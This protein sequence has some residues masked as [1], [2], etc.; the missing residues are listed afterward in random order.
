MNA[1][2]Y[3]GNYQAG[4]KY[5]ERPGAYALLLNPVGLLGRVELPQGYF[6]PGGGIENG[7]NAESALLREIAEETAFQARL[8]LT[9]GEATEYIYTPGKY[10]TGMA[11]PSTFFVAEITEPTGSPS[12][13]PIDWVTPE[14]LQKSLLHQSQQWAVRQF[15]P[16]FSP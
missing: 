5:R 3:F 9:L 13:H 10:A 8:L 7:E 16:Y 1:R 14:V 6:L 12:E 4:V 2:P 11:K 15:T